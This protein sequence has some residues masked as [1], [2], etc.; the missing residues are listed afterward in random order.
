MSESD[1]FASLCELRS[2]ARLCQ[3]KLRMPPHPAHEAHEEA[4]R[5]TARGK[6][7]A[8][9]KEQ[10]LN[11]PDQNSGR[12]PVSAQQASQGRAAEA[13][14][15]AGA[16]RR[17]LR[18][19]TRRADVRGG[20][21]A[22]RSVRAARTA[23]ARRRGC[24]KRRRRVL[25]RETAVVLR[26]ERAED[27][28]DRWRNRR[29]RRPRSRRRGGGGADE[30]APTSRGLGALEA[31]AGGRRGLKAEKRGMLTSAVGAHAGGLDSSATTPPP[32]PLRGAE[33]KAQA[34]DPRSDDDDA[35]ARHS[36]R[37]TSGAA[38]RRPLRAS[39]HLAV[40]SRRQVA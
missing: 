36:P 28:A 7:A 20:G 37:C 40:A 27:G 31:A 16:T 14:K 24:A 12:R 6:T 1:S 17:G 2:S 30:T 5:E 35:L 25:A 19:R 23:R 21:G 26:A 39:E 10:R 34:P 11:S 8:E 9:K 15:R 29:R 38:E 13:K 4:R 33:A 18:S 32:P 22:A 3:T